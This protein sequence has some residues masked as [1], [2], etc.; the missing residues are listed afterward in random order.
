[1]FGCLQQ[2]NNQSSGIASQIQVIDNENVLINDFGK[3][4]FINLKTH[5]NYSFLNTTSEKFIVNFK[6]IDQR[7]LFF[8]MKDSQ[9]DTKGYVLMRFDIKKNNMIE[10]LALPDRL[11]DDSVHFAI[12]LKKKNLAI[13][14]AFFNQTG[15][16][17]SNGHSQTEILV[18]DSDNNRILEQITSI[19]SLN[20]LSYSPNG[21]YLKTGPY[22]WRVYSTSNY[23]NL[24]SYENISIIDT[25]WFNETMV[26][27]LSDDEYGSYMT[28]NFILPNYTPS[29][30]STIKINIP[31]SLGHS[32]Y[33]KKFSIS[34]NKR[35]YALEGLIPGGCSQIS[36]KCD[37]AF[38][39]LF[40]RQTKSEIYVDSGGKR[41]NNKILSEWNSNGQY[42][43]QFT[44]ENEIKMIDPNALS[45]I[46]K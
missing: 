33:F 10:V 5:Q 39:V 22:V 32:S 19:E 26:V 16:N 2:F 6:L 24:I 9:Y 7:Y 40:D 17:I 27:A 18:L 42:I 25:Q 35:Y 13:S 37:E 12:D 11:D 43:Y 41:F 21:S 8:V 14:Y 3:I 36:T 31:D 1:M 34:P 38:V 15:P 45:P 30:D 46:S 29:N 23:S 4:Y 20:S 28:T 44:G